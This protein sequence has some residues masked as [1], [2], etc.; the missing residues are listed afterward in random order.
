MSGC[1][2][3][4]CCTG[5]GKGRVSWIALDAPPRPARPRP[6]W[7]CRWPVRRCSRAPTTPATGRLG[8]RPCPAAREPLIR[9][10]LGRPVQCV[11]QRSDPLASDSRQRGCSTAGCVVPRPDQYYNRVRP[12]CRHLIHFRLLPA[13][14]ILIC[15]HR[16]LSHGHGHNH[17]RY[18]VRQPATTWQAAGQT[19]RRQTRPNPPLPRPAP[20]CAYHRPPRRIGVENGLALFLVLRVPGAAINQSQREA[21]LTRSTFTKSTANKPL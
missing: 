13:Y 6:R 14:K 17:S 16:G 9:V 1:R 19:A 3:R 11:L 18:A 5:L 7:F 20:G 2:S 10:G 8:G 4:R 15:Y 21:A 12:P